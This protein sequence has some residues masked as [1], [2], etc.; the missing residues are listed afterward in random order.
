M[1][2][3]QI[4]NTLI[5]EDITKGDVIAGTGTIEL[6]GTVGEISGVKYKLIGA[7][8]NGAD[9]F[10]APSNNYKEALQV[11]EENNYD[12]EIIEATTFKEVVEKLKNR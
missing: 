7:V 2:T 3:L 11:K 10:I 1:S 12:I 8:K 4:Y 6:D 9:V 5:S